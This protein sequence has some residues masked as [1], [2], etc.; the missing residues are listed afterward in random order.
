MAVNSCV[1]SDIGTSALGVITLLNEEEASLKVFGL[2]KIN[3]IVDIYWPELADYIFKIEELCEDPDFVGNEL[4]NLVASKIYFHLE[5]YSEALKYALCAGKLFNIHE[6][7]KYV[8]TILAKCI[9]KYVEL[10]EFYYENPQHPY[11][12]INDNEDV[13]EL[14]L[15][16]FQ[17]QQEQGAPVTQVIYPVN[18][19]VSAVPPIYSS[20]GMGAS[21]GEENTL[22]DF[23]SKDINTK[24]ESLVDEMLEICIKNNNI[25]QAL[26]VALDA[27]RL[28][29]VKYIIN[30]APNKVEILKHSIKNEKHINAY[31]KFRKR[32]FKLLVD[33]YLTL[34]DEELQEEYI[35]LCECLFHIGDS[36]KVAEILLKLLESNHLMALQI[37]FD[38]VDFENRTFL[39][40]ILKH[41]KY[42]IQMD[43]KFQSDKRSGDEADSIA[44]DPSEATTGNKNAEREPLLAAPYNSETYDVVGTVD[45]D[46]ELV[47]LI[48]ETHPLYD[49]FK[50]IVLVLSGQITISMY[51]E[52]LHRNN[53]ADLVLLDTYKNIVDPRSSITHHGI[54]IAHALMQ[55]GTTCDVFLRSNIEWL[56]KAVHWAKFSAIASLGVVY[57]GHV[58]ES[59]NVLS[60]YLPH[61]DIGSAQRSGTRNA[62]QTPGAGTSG[63]AAT[64]AG[65]SASNN[66]SVYSEGGSLYALGLIH[67]NYRTSD[68]KVRN[69]LLHELRNCNGDEVMQHGCCLGLGLVCLGCSDDEE[70][71][72]ELKSVLYSDSAVAGEGAAYSIGLLK[73]GS[74]DFKC[75]DELLAYAHD[76]QHEKIIRACSIGIGFVLFQKENEAMVVLNE[77]INDKDA[78]IRYGGMFSIGMAYCGLS[79]YN[80]KII[81]KLLHFTVSDV[82]DDVRR[83]AVI[84]LG[85]VLCNT[86]QQVPKFL[87]RLIES[88]NA[89]VRYGAALALGIACAATAN[90]DAVNML[91]PLLLDTTDFVRQSA[92]LALGL[93]FQQANEHVN[94]NF[95]KYKEEIF[96]ILSDKHEDI[97]AKFGAIVSAGLLDICGRNAV[98]TFFTRKGDIIR[99]QA[100]AGFCLFVQLWY[101]FPL[102]HMVSL[103]FLPT[104]LIGLTEDLK[105]PKSF[106]VICNS[107]NPIFDYPAY[108]SKEKSKEKKETVTAVLSTT[109]RRK[110]LR[111]KKTKNERLKPEP[112]PGEKTTQDDTSSV[113]SDGKSM[114]NLDVLSTAATVGQS[115]HVSHSGSLAGSANEEVSTE[116]IN[117]GVA[118]SVPKGKKDKGK[119]MPVTIST[120]ADMK[121]P[122][123]VIKLQEQ[124]IEFPMHSR[125]KPVLPSRKSGF[126]ILMDTAPEEPIEYI[127]RKLEE[128]IKKEAPPFEPFLWK[129]N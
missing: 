116:Q 88:Y 72:D 18:K 32:F 27:K 5:K 11:A 66:G 49:K 92:F 13:D 42:L 73:L 33:I 17:I 47:R 95:K 103:T 14:E 82:S 74:G 21:K 1:G 55:T 44:K 67:A 105:M 124:Y 34:S 38:L 108:V 20:Y 10:R 62:S 60:T 22:T 63:G 91:M 37:A 120:T 122:C 39:K 36:K 100:A 129:E 2:E 75:V 54:I 84:A 117:D 45:V 41:L 89:H 12:E 7:S 77:M 52:F 98:S 29:K 85:F 127:E 16:E 123:R 87:N 79:N 126:V 119:N 112:T 111:L 58:K 107:K 97:I 46:D 30:S 28:D 99:P 106:S 6:K 93:I 59:F 31:K 56:S 65:N 53:H 86:P 51:V 71:Y 104:C 40:N 50:K 115:S 26:G 4:A 24:M 102:I 68:P 3:S 90:E 128:E 80:K 78:I 19:N 43:P 69:Y 113:L 76:T 118:V 83:A 81:K 121:N 125:Y 64:G 23:W 101:W 70:V 109:A 110:T 15:E 48:P 61:G 9:E 25:K 96:K 94:V 114:K 57:K 35:S 8:E